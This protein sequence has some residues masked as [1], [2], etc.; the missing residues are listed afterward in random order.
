MSC[1]ISHLPLSLHLHVESYV[2]SMSA[3]H[4]QLIGL[5]L[6]SLVAAYL[7]YLY[8]QSQKEAAVAFNVAMPLEVRN[9]GAAKKWDEVQGREKQVLENQVRGV[10]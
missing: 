9:N 7:G 6:V 1:L 8:I 10:S 3:E 4:A 2:S 5:A